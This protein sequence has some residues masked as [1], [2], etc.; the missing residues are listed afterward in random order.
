[1]A[2]LIEDQELTPNQAAD[3]LGMSRPLIVQR[4]EAGDLSFRYVGK[5][6]RTRLKDV[7]TLKS[8]LDRQQAA[9]DELVG[10]WPNL[11]AR[12]SVTRLT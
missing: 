7:L 2:V 11:P 8:R 5:H 12:P 3:I 9:L 10:G 1:M 4:M 6:R